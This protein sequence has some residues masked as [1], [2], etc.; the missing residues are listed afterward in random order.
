MIT[1]ILTLGIIA[2]VVGAMALGSKL[3]GRPLRGSCGGVDRACLC[4]IQGKDPADCPLTEAGSTV[5]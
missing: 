2:S 5:S 3:V 1:F 4:K